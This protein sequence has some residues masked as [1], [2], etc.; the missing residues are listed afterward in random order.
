MQRNAYPEWS[1]SPSRH[2]LFE[3]CRRKYYYHYYAAHN[4]WLADAPE[5]AKQAYRLKQMTNLYLVFG[6]AM[7]KMAETTLMQFNQA[8]RLLEADELTRRVRNLLNQAYKDSLDQAAWREQPKKRTMLHEMYY[9]GELPHH[10]TDTIKRRIPILA[11]RFLGSRSLQ[12]F[13]QE[14]QARLLEIE[15]LN[16]IEVAGTKVYVKLDF[17]FRQDNRHVIVDWKTGQE[18]ERNKTQLR[19]Y[20][21]YVHRMYEVPYERLDI[22]TEYLLSGQCYEDQVEGEEM[23]EL[24]RHVVTSIQLMRD[25]LAE[26]AINRPL[27]VDSF[28]PTENARRCRRCAFLEICEYGQRSEDTSSAS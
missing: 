21:L 19:L 28:E 15:R 25:Y 4:G 23:A 12:Q 17:M 5:L 11:D 3:E 27:S 1:W 7:H 2:T 14:Q 18:D 6:D 26:P 20:G 9:D 10:V 8:G 22:R 24:E 13:V 16:T